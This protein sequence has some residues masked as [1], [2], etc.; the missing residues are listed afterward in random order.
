MN[1]PEARAIGLSGSYFHPH[2]TTVTSSMALSQSIHTTQF[3]N[4]LAYYTSQ[5]LR[6][7]EDVDLKI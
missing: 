1:S 3:V 5:A 4:Q 6:S 2:H 7:Q